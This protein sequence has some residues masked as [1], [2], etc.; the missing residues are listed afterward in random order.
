MAALWEGIRE[1]GWPARP[2]GESFPALSS[3]TGDQGRLDGPA[4]SECSYAFLGKEYMILGLRMGYHLSTIEAMST[5][6]PSKNF[7]RLQ[8]TDGGAAFDR[9]VRRVRLIERILS[10]LGF[11]CA[12]QGDFLD[13]RM[14]YLGRD[15]AQR[16]LRVLG[17]LTML[18]KQLD[19][20]LSN[21]DI[22]DWYAR[23]LMRQLGLDEKGRP[24][25]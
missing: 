14:S 15:A 2:P 11:A 10:R 19:M 4:F 25:R 1:E 23:D 7:I 21:D 20:A 16:N 3:A 8:H 5:S 22:A 17:R 9:K 6:E 12:R 18:T 13:A 24:T